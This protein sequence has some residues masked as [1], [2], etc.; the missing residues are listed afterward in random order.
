LKKITVITINYNN[1]EGLART[2]QSVINQTFQDFDYIVV[3]GN[4]TDDSREVINRSNDAFRK[5]II[6]PDTGIY[7]AM[8]KGL[9]FTE[10]EYVLYLNSGDELLHPNSLEKAVSFL[11]GTA[12]ISFDI[13]VR[14][15]HKTYVKKYPENPNFNYFL[16]ESLPHPAT[17]INTT[18]LRNY[19][20]YDESLKIVS[21]WAF[22]IKSI[23]K[24][25]ASYKHV[26]EALSVFYTDGL[27]SKKE[28]AAFIAKE[29][30]L[31]LEK[32]FPRFTELSSEAAELT[33]Y[34]R[35]F[36]GSLILRALVRLKIIQKP[37]PF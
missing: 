19:G 28:N 10:T 36:A 22:F 20:G 8:N 12:L 33:S 1:S 2:I 32:E 6:E 15:Q 9:S 26:A 25:N 7:N 30:K 35:L 13:E 24:G 16:I 5:T 21:D 14:Q 27:S 34:R 4:S 3:D 17:F 31:F 29:K 37:E 18:M 23:C 11:D